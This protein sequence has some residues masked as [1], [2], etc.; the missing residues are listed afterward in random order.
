MYNPQIARSL[1]TL[2]QVHKVGYLEIFLP[3]MDK[4]RRKKYRDQLHH[5]IGEIDLTN[6]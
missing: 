2:R 6:T 4:T 5:I 1:K 3:K